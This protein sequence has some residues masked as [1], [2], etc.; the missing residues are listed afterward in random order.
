MIVLVHMTQNLKPKMIGKDSLA[1]KDLAKNKV[2]G[3]AKRGRNENDWIRFVD[4][5]HHLDCSHHHELLMTVTC[6]NTL[7]TWS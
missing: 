4:A 2:S 3:H 1:P 5:Y 6:L 7:M